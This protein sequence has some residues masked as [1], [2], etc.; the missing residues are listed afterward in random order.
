MLPAGTIHFSPAPPPIMTPPMPCQFPLSHLWSRPMSAGCRLCCCLLLPLFGCVT[1][2]AQDKTAKPGPLEQA[3]GAFVEQLHR[4]EFAAAT[5]DFDATMTKVMPAD[6]LKKTWETVIGDVGAFQKR[7][8]TRVQTVDKH[9]VVHVICQFARDKRDVRVV[10]DKDAKIAGLFFSPAMPTGAEEVYEGKLKA[11]AVEIRLV[12]HLF[13]QKDGSYE[14]T[15][16]SPDQGAKGLVLNAASVKD[17][18][19]RLELSAAKIVFE[20]QRGKDG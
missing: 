5:K 12:F 4:E 14:G 10:F 17:D 9:N 20:G 16:D 19:V 8:S 1:A 3:A 11:G 13:K 6:E 15:M 7:L 2:A 18:M